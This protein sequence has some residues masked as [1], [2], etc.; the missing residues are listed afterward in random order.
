[1]DTTNR[2]EPTKN[3]TSLERTADRELVITR[4]I[5][6]PPSLVFSAWTR[7]ELFQ[8][9]WVPKSLGMSFV[10]C[11]VDARTGGGYRFVFR[12]GEHTMA[13]HGRY[14]EVTPH[15]RI[16]WTNEE[17]EDGAVTTLTFEPIGS[18]T[19]L[20]LHELYP[21]KEALEAALASG[22]KSCLDETFGQLDELLASLPN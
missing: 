22:E 2:S 14:V 6:G 5:D 18:K 12:Y 15:S 20:T 3:L 13:F 17:A 19:R 21:S 16:V 4:T 9:W 1:M 7:A 11:E 8:Q 10:S